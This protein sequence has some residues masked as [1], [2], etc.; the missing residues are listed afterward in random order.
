MSQ[1]DCVF[2]AAEAARL[3]GVDPD[4][5]EDTLTAAFRAQV[6]RT[7]P[8]RPGGDAERLRAVIAAYH[9]LRAR[10]RAPRSVGAR[11]APVRAPGPAILEISAMEALFGVRRT[12]AAAGGRSR[13]ARLPAGLRAGERVR[14][15]GEVMTVAIAS[16]GAF[17]VIGDHVC[18]TQAVE[19]QV[20]RQGGLVRV[21]TPRG[22]RQV[23]IT[24]QDAIR[25][26][27][28]LSGAGLPA[29]GVRPQGDLLIWLKTE[30][31]AE[32][33]LETPAQV[34]LRR[35]TADWAA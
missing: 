5:A 16:A 2:E 19:P 1:G 18:L 22:P 23:R 32:V 15:G 8:D 26:L 20:L 25:G 29:R 12:I 34:K 9:H 28:R 3:L 31:E 35:F 10:P 21:E 6:K 13:L 27:A 30:A 14:L 7:H 17:A 33:R 24:R 4:C 11:V